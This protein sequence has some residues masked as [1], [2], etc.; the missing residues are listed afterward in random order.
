MKTASEQGAE[1]L[2]KLDEVIDPELGLGIVALGLVYHIRINEDDSVRIIM[3]LTVPGCPMHETITA[4]VR[5]TIG[6][7]SWV[8]DVD[9]VVTFDP[10]WT[11]ERLTPAARA[12][13]GKR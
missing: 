10:P 12:A 3:T 1:V 11:P 8:K 2:A 13:L 7:I 5:R 9:V 6:A 4:D